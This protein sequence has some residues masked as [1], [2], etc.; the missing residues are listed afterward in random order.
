MRCPLT[1]FL[2][3]LSAMVATAQEAT[4]P[5]WSFAVAAPVK[6]SIGSP[7][8][9]RI[10]SPSSRPLVLNVPDRLRFR[11]PQYGL[12]A[13]VSYTVKPR[14]RAGVGAGLSGN[15]SERDPTF[16][17]YTQLLVPVFATVAFDIPVSQSIDLSISGRGGHQWHEQQFGNGTTALV[18]SQRGGAFVG[19]GVTI[20]SRAH[21]WHPQLSLGYEYQRF[22]YAYAFPTPVPGPVTIFVPPAIDDSIPQISGPVNTTPYSHMLTL[23]LGVRF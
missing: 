4:A 6:F 16:G 23:G 8:T 18:I 1:L 21:R 14:L 10:V 9:Q 11:Q 2:F 3:V 20:L 15:F 17:P 12:E 19:G 7:T 13:I 22:Q 5:R